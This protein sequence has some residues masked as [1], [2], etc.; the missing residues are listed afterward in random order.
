MPQYDKKQCAERLFLDAYI[1]NSRLR[2][3][4]VCGDNM[5][6]QVRRHSNKKNIVG[7]RNVQKSRW[8]YVKAGKH[9]IR[10]LHKH[11]KERRFS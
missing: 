6:V 1:A 4:V 8:C 7:P 11:N 5:D 10:M 3:D 9:D 2:Q